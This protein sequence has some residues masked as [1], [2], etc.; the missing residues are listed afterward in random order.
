[1]GQEHG[2]G[3]CADGG[4]SAKP[5]EADGADVE[6]FLG[7]DRHEIHC[8]AEEDGE[9]VEGERGEDDLLAPDEFQA[10]EQLAPLVNVL[11]MGFWV[12][13][14]DEQEDEK[15]DVENSCNDIDGGGGDPGDDESRY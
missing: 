15:E 1:M 4:C 10:G 5:A 7:E 8:P 2:H 14:H 6:N 12:V 13:A 9:K 3:E 11:L